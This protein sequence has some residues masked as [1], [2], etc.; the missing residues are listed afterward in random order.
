MDPAGDVGVFWM[1]PIF[2]SCLLGG[3]AFWCAGAQADETRSFVPIAENMPQPSILLGV[4]DPIDD[5]DVEFVTR[6]DTTEINLGLATPCI[7]TTA[8][9]TAVCQSADLKA[10]DDQLEQLWLAVVDQSR[11]GADRGA[12]LA[13]Q[14]Q[15]RLDREACGTDEACLEALFF[16][17]IAVV[18]ARS[19]TALEGSEVI[20]LVQEELNTLSCG[21]GL[22][23][24]I[25][26]EQT[27]AALAR[28]AALEP[29][30]ELS[31]GPAASETLMA[32]RSLP[33]GLCSY[34]H[35]A[36]EQAFLLEGHWTLGVSA[37]PEGGETAR[38]MKVRLIS[39][40]GGPT[41]TGQ[42]A[43]DGG[44]FDRQIEAHS[45]GDELTVVAYD[46]GGGTEEN[47]HVYSFTAGD[48]PQVFQGFDQDGCR[49]TMTR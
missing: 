8:T 16:Q 45:S 20:R 23:D 9:E 25:V 41:Y 35:R 42:I 36:S 48:E 7:Q 31:G 17:Q 5:P 13:D 44:Q 10:L 37:C 26:G 38:A 15:M 33:A 19:V 21:A 2:R 1:G 27:E 6:Q 30:A 12:A 49:L 4:I 32:L 34:L 3:V 47:R 28:V 40:A 29:T 43:F 22:A 11:G 14:S 46:L 24:G 39:T 18:G